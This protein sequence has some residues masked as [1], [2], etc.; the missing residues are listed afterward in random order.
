[1]LIILIFEI[2]TVW[3]SRQYT[4]VD[5]IECSLHEELWTK[6]ELIC[7]DSN[8]YSVQAD[9]VELVDGLKMTKRRFGSWKF[10]SCASE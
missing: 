7:G 5:W 2:S 8:I 1:M 6:G 4:E 9:N 10:I 3:D